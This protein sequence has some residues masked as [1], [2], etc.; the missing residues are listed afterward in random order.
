MMAAITTMLHSCTVKNPNRT[1][2]RLRCFPKA[3]VNAGLTESCRDD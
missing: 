1:D 2:T 3:D